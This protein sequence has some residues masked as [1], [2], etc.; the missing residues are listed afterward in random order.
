VSDLP[1]FHPLRLIRNTVKLFNNTYQPTTPTGPYG[2]F[3]EEGDGGNDGGDTRSIF[4]RSVSVARL[5]VDGINASIPPT[6]RE[7]FEMLDHLH[8]RRFIDNFRARFN[9]ES[10]R[11]PH[12]HQD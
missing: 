10:A 3:R 4:E 8:L 5:V 6:V 11:I 12:L 9:F 1:P 7:K 2:G